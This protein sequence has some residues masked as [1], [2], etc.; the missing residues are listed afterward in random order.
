MSEEAQSDL[1]LRDTL[2]RLE[3][4]LMHPA[5]RNDRSRTAALIAEEF[6]EFG[7]SG[8]VWNYATI[9]DLL[10]TELGYSAPVVEDFI[11]RWIAPATALVTYRTLRTDS[12]LVT[13]TLRSSIWIRNDKGW[14]II[15]HQGTTVPSASSQL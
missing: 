3:L 2:L 11:T 14:Q 12:N 15:F 13:Q 9:L 5:T 10:V 6:I 7:A 8:K 4:E 1:N